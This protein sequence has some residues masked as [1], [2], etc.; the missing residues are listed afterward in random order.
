MT[1]IDD[2]LTNLRREFSLEK[3]VI[4]DLNSTEGNTLK[5]KYTLI[6]EVQTDRKIKIHNQ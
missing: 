6:N 4:F 5:T 3:I 1:D 2:I